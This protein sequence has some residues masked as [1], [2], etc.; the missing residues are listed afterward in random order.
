[1]AYQMAATAVTLND[2]YRSFTGCMS[3]RM[4]SIKQFCT[5]FYRIL[6]ISVLTVPLR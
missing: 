5:A 6:T 3:F 4:Q 1:M 2:L